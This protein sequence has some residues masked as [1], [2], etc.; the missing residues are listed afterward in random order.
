MH[1]QLYQP[2]DKK[3]Y[4]SFISHM[5]YILLLI[6]VDRTVFSNQKY[7]RLTIKSTLSLHDF[8]DEFP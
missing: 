2:A 4:I 3:L 7:L 6:I 1:Q 8:Y 5:F